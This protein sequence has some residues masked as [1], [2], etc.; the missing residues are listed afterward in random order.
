MEQG[1]HETVI[2]ST[3]VIR[4]SNYNRGGI[5]FTNSK[6]V[7]LKSLTI[8]SCEAFLILNTDQ[9]MLAYSLLT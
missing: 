4:C 5:Q 9:V 7:L 2:L 1:F 3:S 8:A 6:A